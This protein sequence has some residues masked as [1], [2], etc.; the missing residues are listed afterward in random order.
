M[1]RNFS[2]ASL[3]ASLASLG[4]L[5]GRTQPPKRPPL[6]IMCVTEGSAT[7]AAD[8]R[9]EYLGGGD[10]GT[11]VYPRWSSWQEVWCWP[12]PGLEHPATQYIEMFTRHQK[13]KQL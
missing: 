4:I 7:S 2:L 1:H 8:G 9:A 10:A 6:A 13:H 12:P 11:E 3:R 5:Q